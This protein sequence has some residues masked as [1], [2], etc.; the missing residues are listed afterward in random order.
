MNTQHLQTIETL[1][2]IPR[3]IHSL[4]LA[5]P[6]VA[7]PLSPK[8]HLIAGLFGLFSKS[9]TFT[10]A[11]SC[12]K[13][14]VVIIF[15]NDSSL[16][17]RRL[18]VIWPTQPFRWRKAGILIEPTSS[19]PRGRPSTRQKLFVAKMSRYSGYQTG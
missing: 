16:A 18:Q 19:T 11:K 7:A 12:D 17:S 2:K 1:C 6:P 9:K 10:A 15:Q 5:Y 4:T 3:I 8:F 13:L 14:I